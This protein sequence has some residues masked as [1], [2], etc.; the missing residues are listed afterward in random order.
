MSWHSPA[1]GLPRAWPRP[2]WRV[3]LLKTMAANE[4]ESRCGPKESPL[5]GKRQLPS[6]SPSAG[7]PRARD[8][9]CDTDLGRLLAKPTKEQQLERQKKL[10]LDAPV[11][12]AAKACGQPN[13]YFQRGSPIKPY[14][15]REMAQDY[16]PPTIALC[17]EL[18]AHIYTMTKALFPDPEQPAR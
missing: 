1:P 4:L 9:G 7:A 3:D 15:E 11:V 8:S 5:T 6:P 16:Q 12:V 13:A 2:D 14:L 10:V 18:A 17:Y